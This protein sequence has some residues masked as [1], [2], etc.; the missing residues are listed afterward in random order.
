M[1]SIPALREEKLLCSFCSQRSILT[2]INCMKCICSL[3]RFHESCSPATIPSNIITAKTRNP[4]ARALLAKHFPPSQK[5]KPTMIQVTKSTKGSG[6]HLMRMKHRAIPLVT[7]DVST[8]M[9]DRIHFKVVLGP[10]EE[11]FW[12]R[13]SLIMGRAVDLI[14]RRLNVTIS[15]IKPA[16]LTSSTGEILRNDQTTSQIENGETV[17]FVVGE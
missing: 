16:Y 12:C 9:K 10:Q 5:P 4:E 14:A 17:H 13:N 2:C 3:H 7:G 11:I 1:T 6:V 8:A 15:D